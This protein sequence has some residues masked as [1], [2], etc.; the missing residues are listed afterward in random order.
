MRVMVVGQKWLAEVVAL[1]LSGAGH[2]VAAV[3]VPRLDDRLARVGLALN[4][5]VVV[6]ERRLSPAAVP[7]GTD[8][9]LCAYAHCFVDRMARG[10]ARLGAIGYHPSL[11]PRHRGRDAVEWAIRFGDPI[12]GGTVY[13]LDDGADTGPVLQQEWCWVRPGDNAE[14]LWRRELAPMGRRLLGTVVDDLALGRAVGQPQRE[15]VATFEPAIGGRALA[16]F[17][18]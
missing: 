16:M 2:E 5:E 6:A 7:P 4:A 13:Q 18:G 1:D 11:L 17:P 9:I 8:L 12:T 3:A 14:A 10:R 15:D